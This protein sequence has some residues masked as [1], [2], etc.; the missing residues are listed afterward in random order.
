MNIKHITL[1]FTCTLLTCCYNRAINKEDN[2][3][4][5]N[6]IIEGDLAEFKNLFKTGQATINDVVDSGNPLIYTIVA[7]YAAQRPF[8]SRIPVI[9]V[10]EKYN[11]RLEMI[12]FLVQKGADIN[13]IGEEG[14]TALHKAVLKDQPK[15]VELLLELGAD[16]SVQNNAGLI[17]YAIAVE[18]GYKEI[19]D[20]FDRHKMR[21]GLSSVRGQTK[22]PK[23]V[24]MSLK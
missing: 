2:D 13:A 9:P 19:K 21:S 6:S 22:N 3:I 7:W 24:F 18:E 20:L 17:P 12:R 11:N 5:A 15:V 4:L 14:N 8:T 16:T 1:L 10:S 23:D